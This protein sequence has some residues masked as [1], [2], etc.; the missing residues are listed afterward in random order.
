MTSRDAQMHKKKKKCFMIA[1][2][3]TAVHGMSYSSAKHSKSQQFLRS[4]RNSMNRGACV[5]IVEVAM[6]PH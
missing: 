5:W 3:F 1:L 6:Q 2:R 4:L